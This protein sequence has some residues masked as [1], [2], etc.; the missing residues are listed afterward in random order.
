MTR[1]QLAILKTFYET[2]LIGGSLPFTFPD[3]SFG[4]TILVKFPKG[5]QPSWQ[6]VNAS[7]Y[8]VNITLSVLP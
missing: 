4:G 1:A 5:G 7:V 8:R 6:Q 2:T 3:P